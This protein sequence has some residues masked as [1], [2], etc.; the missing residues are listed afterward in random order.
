MDALRLTETGRFQGSFNLFGRV[1][2][3]P[4]Y[5][6]LKFLCRRVRAVRLVAD[7]EAAARPYYFRDLSKA[8]FYTV[9]NAVAR[10]K[11]SSGRLRSDTSP[12]RT[13][14]RPASIIPRL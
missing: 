7:Q 3:H 5:D 12:C 8:V 14:Q 1:A 9:S 6:F 10:S 4:V 13:V 11:L 2:A